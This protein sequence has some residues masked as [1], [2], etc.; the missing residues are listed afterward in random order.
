[1]IV[2]T[3]D[4]CGVESRSATESQPVTWSRLE[5]RMASFGQP[6]TRDFC[7]LCTKDICEQKV[8]MR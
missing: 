1:M 7:T 4:R 8:P 2:V 3:C 6:T 5:V